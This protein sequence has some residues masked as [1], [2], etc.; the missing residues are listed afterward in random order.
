MAFR[1]SL[2]F[3]QIRW[4]LSDTTSSGRPYVVAVSGTNYSGLTQRYSP[5]NNVNTKTNS[6]NMWNCQCCNQTLGGSMEH[7]V[8][9]GSIF[10]DPAQPNNQLT[11]PTQPVTKSCSAVG[12]LFGHSRH[13]PITGSCCAPFPLGGGGGSPSNTTSPGPRPTSV[14]LPSGILIHPQY[15]NVTNRRTDRTTIP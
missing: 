2:K 6:V 4:S 9:R 15:A 3:D 7:I 1:N 13:G 14:G 11:D 12:R 5:P 8:V 10:F